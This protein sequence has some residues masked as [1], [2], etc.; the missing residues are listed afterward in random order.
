M[1]DHSFQELLN[2]PNLL[3]NLS[4]REIRE[5]INKYPYSIHLKLIAAKRDILDKKELSKEELNKLALY[6]PD[7]SKLSDLL[8]FPNKTSTATGNL[9]I[10]KE[11]KN[12]NGHPEA[13]ILQIR[14]K[15]ETSPD[16]E[17]RQS[18]DQDSS[19]AKPIVEGKRLRKLIKERSKDHATAADEFS[20][21]EQ[22]S[23][24]KTALT[25][26]NP[27]IGGREFTDW[28]KKLDS[29]L[30]TDQ[31]INTTESIESDEE[32]VSQELAELLE[33][34]GHFQEALKM[35]E[36][37]I[38]TN[39]EKSTLFAQKISELKEKIE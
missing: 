14:Q 21:E 7:S 29:R 17:Q 3:M 33:N 32:L 36:K 4:K 28:L 2:H 19:K 27:A 18:E 26:K 38:L 12:G 15:N 11:S 24:I 10:V 25:P 8:Q 16:K 22:H 13:E 37:L 23:E 31:P 35:F 5:L 9:N 1:M 20:A 34:Q 30:V 39:P 6:L